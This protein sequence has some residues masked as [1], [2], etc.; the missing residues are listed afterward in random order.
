MTKQEIL[1]ERY[2]NAVCAA[3]YYTAKKEVLLRMDDEG[4]PIE[5]DLLDEMSAGAEKFRRKVAAYRKAIKLPD[6]ERAFTDVFRFQGFTVSAG[7][8]EGDTKNVESICGQFFKDLNTVSADAC[9]RFEVAAIALMYAG[10]AKITFEQLNAKPKQGFGRKVLNI[11][12]GMWKGK[13][14]WQ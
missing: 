7:F 11:L 6:D 1:F 8:L 13:K 5:R 2:K 3:A 10:A 4:I 12:K 9:L 14:A